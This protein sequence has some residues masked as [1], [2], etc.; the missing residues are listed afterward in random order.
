MLANITCWVIALGMLF[1]E[2]IDRRDLYIKSAIA[3]GFIF[4]GTISKAVDYYREIHIKK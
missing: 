1:S 4:V 3:I 2:S